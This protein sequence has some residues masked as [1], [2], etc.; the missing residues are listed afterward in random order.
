MK[1]REKRYISAVHFHQTYLSL[2]LSLHVCM[3]AWIYICVLFKYANAVADLIVGAFG[4]DKAVLYRYRVHHKRL[5]L[6]LSYSL[7]VFILF[8]CFLVFYFET[9]AKPIVNASASLTVQPTML[10]PE[11]KTCELH[12]VEES[13]AVPWY[14]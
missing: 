9:R 2:A 7:C 11:E 13:V 6:E 3:Y 1:F 10:N 14:V 8:S 12:T 5:I 4:A